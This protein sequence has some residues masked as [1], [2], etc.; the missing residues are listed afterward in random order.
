MDFTF[1]LACNGSDTVNGNLTGLVKLEY[2]TSGDWDHWV[3]AGTSSMCKH[4]VVDLMKIIII[5]LHSFFR[6]YRICIKW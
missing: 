3:T 6:K 5:L 2:R 1:S 4:L